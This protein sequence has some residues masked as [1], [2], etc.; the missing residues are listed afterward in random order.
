M[1]YLLIAVI[2]HSCARLFTFEESDFPEQSPPTLVERQQLHN[3]SARQN[4]AAL[5]SDTQAGN[6]R[7][8]VS[9][10]YG[11]DDRRDNHMREFERR[12]VKAVAS[13]LRPLKETYQP[14]KLI[15]VAESQILSAARKAITADSALKSLKCDELAKDLGHFTTPEIHQYLAKQQLVSSPYRAA[16]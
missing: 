16:L 15:L 10:P 12:F 4:A 13:E 1:T 8:T 6:N 5:W 7:S 3:E 11:Y 9:N 14:R 2:D